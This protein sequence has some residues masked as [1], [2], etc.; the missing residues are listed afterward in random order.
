MA[1][2][3]DLR[4][5][6]QRRLLSALLGHGV[7][8][9]ADL[10]RAVGL[11]QPSVGTIVDELLA[12]QILEIAPDSEGQGRGLRPRTSRAAHDSPRIGRPG[13]LVRLD[14][15]RLRFLAVELGVRHTRLAR[16]PVGCEDLAWEIAVPTSR[17][18]DEW[19]R[20]LAHATREWA[21]Q[22]MEAVLISVPGVVDESRGKVLLCPNM[23]WVEKAH[24]PDLLSAVCDA[25]A[26]IVQ[27]IR[28]LAL[29]H[30][31]ANPAGGDF[32]LVDIGDGV[33]GAA[34]IGGRLFES[35]L[36]LSGELGHDPVWGNKRP[37]GCGA[38][39]CVETLVSRRGLLASF[40]AAKRPGPH[41]WATLIRHIAEHGVPSWLKDSLDALA[42]AIAGALNILGLRRVV[43]TGILG[44]LPAPVMAHLSAAVIAGAM[45][46]RFGEVTCEAASRR[47]MAG[48]VS[49]AIDRI[50]LQNVDG[51]AGQRFRLVSDSA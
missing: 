47:R 25:P 13:Q 8:T 7:A 18:Q 49:A 6:N 31:A 4:R 12:A 2:T 42:M 40:V 48:L 11:S 9:R 41:T 37:C 24:L 27:E 28:A 30:L 17:A 20:R 39:G 21:G 29:G 35:P 43:V 36:P 26:L 16:L 32:L 46:A 50:L 33:G 34:V 1:T 5:L 45:W 38:L 44:E 15:T 22:P 23:R 10:A 3:S 19:V 51:T 14:R